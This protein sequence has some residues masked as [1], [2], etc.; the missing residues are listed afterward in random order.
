MEKSDNNQTE[1]SYLYALLKRVPL[2]VIYVPLPCGKRCLEGISVKPRDL[3]GQFEPGALDKV[4]FRLNR[5][6]EI[7]KDC[8]GIRISSSVSQ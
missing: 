5:V 3:I 8:L 6:T 1:P 4:P 7:V 2:A